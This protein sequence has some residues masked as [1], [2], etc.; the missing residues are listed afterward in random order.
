[1]RRPTLSYTASTY[2]DRAVFVTRW[3]TVFDARGGTSRALK[4]FA[5][6]GFSPKVWKHFEHRQSGEF[7]VWLLFGENDKFD[8]VWLE[9]MRSITP[10][11]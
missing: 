6:R 5:G 7:E 10:L 11:L 1:M 8:N 2:G 3:Q 4:F 9:I